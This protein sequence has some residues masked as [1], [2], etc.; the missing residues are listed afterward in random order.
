[1]IRT[2]VIAAIVSSST[3]AWAGGLDL[4]NW[5]QS[6]SYSPPLPPPNPK[7]ADDGKSA[8]NGFSID[9]T[10]YTPVCVAC[11]FW[12]WLDFLCGCPAGYTTQQTFS[13]AWTDTSYTTT[14][15]GS[16]GGSIGANWKVVSVQVNA[17]GSTTTTY[18]V[19]QGFCSLVQVN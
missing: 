9:T 12:E 11:P 4:Q 8:C 1:M 14:V 3:L 18:L 6:N 15:T 2:M 17:D 7:A 16:A 13:L 19:T 5:T 10:T